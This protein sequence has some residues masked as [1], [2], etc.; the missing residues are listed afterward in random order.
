MN[1]ALTLSLRVFIVIGWGVI[2]LLTA[3]G[4]MFGA[5]EAGLVLEVPAGG[6]IW[7]GLVLATVVAGCFAAILLA[8]WRLL[9][10][11]DAA[12]IFSARSYTYVDMIIWAALIG[13][14]ACA[15]GVLVL[16]SMT[17]WSLNLP[18]LELGVVMLA[19]LA[20]AGLMVVMKN[21]LRQAVAARDELAAVI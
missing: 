2:A 8:I 13:A 16:A 19:A 10:L 20:F 5:Q 4:W 15:G 12:D 6:A 21:L 11:V 9:G 7:V 3:Y 18:A 14:A 1:R 17:S